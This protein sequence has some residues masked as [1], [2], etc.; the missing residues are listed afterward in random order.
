MGFVL[1]SMGWPQWE[2]KCL[3]SQRL[4]VPGWEDTQRAPSSLEEKG[5]WG[6]GEGLWEGMT[7]KGAVSRM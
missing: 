4:E 6:E 3:A 2:G 5:K 7:R 1:L